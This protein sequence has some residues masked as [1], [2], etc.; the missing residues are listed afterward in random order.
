MPFEMFTGIELDIT[1]RDWD[2]W[3]PVY[4]EVSMKSV[5]EMETT[6]EYDRS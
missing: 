4:F 2:D 1:N 5:N 3:Y 6:Y